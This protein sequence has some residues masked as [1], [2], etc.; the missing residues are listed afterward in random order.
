MAAK[1]NAVSQAEQR[2]AR[3]KRENASQLNQRNADVAAKQQNHDVIQRR[4]QRL[5]EQLVATTI[6][7]PTDGLVV[8]ATT[9]D[10]NAQN[11]IQEGATVR[12]RQLLL[13]LPDT[14]S[15]KAVVRVP[16]A[17]VGRLREGQRA[18]VAINV[19]GI[20]RTIGGTVTKISVLADSGGRWW[21]DV[22]EYPVDVVLDETPSAL[23]PNLSVGVEVLIDKAENAIKAPLTAI[24]SVGQQAYAFVPGGDGV[25]PRPVRLGRVNETDAEIVEGLGTGDRVLILQAGQGRDLLERAGIQAEAPTTRPNREF[26]QRG[27]P[28]GGN[29]SQA[30]GS[31]PREGGG[32]RESR[33]ANRPAS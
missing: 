9:G 30:P 8:Y 23:R 11:P 17:Q 32:N 25:T 21:N 27:G 1:Q 6:K 12:E 31:T 16:E 4:A 24:Y 18:R 7:A 15:M 26:R 2:L 13:R 10:R 20:N 22:K 19:A 29:G 28:P 33:P 3:T 14:S 5:Q